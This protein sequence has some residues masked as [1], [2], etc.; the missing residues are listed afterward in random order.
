MAK[1]TKRR[2][3]A[4]PPSPAG[5]GNGG[6][7][8]AARGA[9]A[10]RSERGRLI[11]LLPDLGP[12]G[13]A[14]F[15]ALLAA[16]ALA[17]ILGG[18]PSGPTYGSD[19]AL[20]L[21]RILV[22]LAALCLSI[23]PPPSRPGSGHPEG[24][25]GVRAAVWTLLGLTLASLLVHSRFLTSPVL[26]FAMLPATLDWLCYALVFT[27]ALALARDRKALLLL[28]EALLVGAAW[29]ALEGAREYGDYVQAGSP[30][31][32]VQA[33]FVSPNFAAGFLGLCLPI[34]AAAFLRARSNLLVVITVLCAAL[35]A[36]VLVATGSRLGIAAAGA[37]L[38]AA[39]LM[40]LIGGL[41]LPWG[42]I[43]ALAAAAGWQV[44]VS[45]RSGET[46]DDWLADLAVGWGGDQIKVGSITR[47]E[48]LAKYN[49][50][51]AIEA[52]TGL[53]VADPPARGASSE[54]ALSC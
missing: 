28:V 46:E 48:R 13:R 33:T 2:S 43:G 47:S 29:V 30:Q 9:T 54:R 3:S 35:T 40:A 7:H 50:L 4:P 45:A 37:G 18:L 51:L 19:P 38:G 36:G 25:R 20:G 14:G 6:V 22:L 53:P 21:L 16:L 49:R 27:L 26:L 23:Q 8:P 10:A 12:L 41:R 1:P 44:T 34:A 15:C 39:F 32:R 5:A 42:R 17:P 31:G 24:T 52:E 11:G